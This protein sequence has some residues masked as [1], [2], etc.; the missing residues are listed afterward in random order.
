MDF[1]I[2]E[3]LAK[4]K[5]KNSAEFKIFKRDQLSVDGRAMPY[6]DVLSHFVNKKRSLEAKHAKNWY[7][8]TE[9][10]NL[11]SVFLLSYLKERGIE[12]DFISYLPAE[13]DKFESALRRPELKAIAITTTFYVNTFQVT[14]IAARVRKINPDIK[15]VTGGPLITNLYHDLT[16][17]RLN[18]AFDE[19]GS[20]IYVLEEQGE[21]TLLELLKTLKEGGDLLQVSNCFVRTGTTYFYTGKA[22]EDNKL[23]DIVVNWDHFPDEQM[24]PTIQ[25]RT[26]RSCAFSCNFC[27]YPIRAGALALTDVQQVEREL[28]QLHAR[29]VKNLVFIDDTFNIPAKRF[30]EL[31]RMM[32]ANKFGF[33]WFSYFRCGNIRSTESYDLMK[34]SGCAGVFLGIESADNVVLTNMNKGANAQQYHYGIEQLNLRGIPS[35][36]SFITG[37]PGETDQ[38]I[39]NN[40]EFINNSKPTFFRAEPFWYNHRSPIYKLADKY[41]L[42]GDGYRWKHNTMDVH[43]ACLAVDRMFNEVTE[44][45]WMPMFMFDFWALPY[46]LGKGLKLSEIVDFMKVAQK[47]IAAQDDPLAY[48]RTMKDLE[49]FCGAL[50]VADAKYSY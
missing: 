48:S 10:P 3:T 41:S 32:I 7:H 14:D 23:N 12:A 8:I 25:L 36:A 31:C 38:S 33:S 50:P 15:I 9:V 2:L 17:E 4:A 35:F 29:G 28:R 34:E 47:A 24:G 6:F 45:T 20:D 21:K 49:V 42:E 43:Q 13:L 37:F 1:K 40:I 16:S 27:D 11:A 44:S 46:L 19:M 18:F 26:A 39:T 30:Q 22:K 5:G